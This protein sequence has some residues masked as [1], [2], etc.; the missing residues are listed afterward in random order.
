MHSLNRRTCGTYTRF[1][2]VNGLSVLVNEWQL[3]QVH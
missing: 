2:V 1:T 3:L